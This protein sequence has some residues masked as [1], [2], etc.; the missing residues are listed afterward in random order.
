MN[1]K[2]RTLVILT[3]TGFMLSGCKAELDDFN[4][5]IK[6]ESPQT[7]IQSNPVPQTMDEQPV[8]ETKNEKVKLRTPE[9]LNLNKYFVFTWDRVEYA[10]GY[11]VNVDSVEYS[12]SVN[13]LNLKNVLREKKAYYLYVK[14]ISNSTSFEDSDFSACYIYDNKNVEDEEIKKEGNFS[15]F[16]DVYTQEAFI[17]YGYDVINSSYINSYEVKLNYPIFDFEKVMNKRLLMVKE[18]Q[19]EDIYIS[20]NSMESY[21]QTF[22]AKASAKAKIK[23]AFSGQIKGSFQQTKSSTTSAL[24][25]SYQHSTTCYQLVLQCSFDEYREML[26]PSFKEDLLHLDIGTLFDRYGTHVITSVLMGGRFDL[27]YTMLSDEEIDTS[28][29]SASLD[30][31]FKAWAIDASINVSGDIEEKAKAS[32][33]DIYSTSHVFG[34]NYTQMNNENAILKNYSKWIESIEDKPSLVGIRDVNSLVGIWELLGDSDQ[35]QARKAELERVFEKYGEDSYLELLSNYSITPPTIPQSVDVEVKDNRGNTV[36]L[37]DVANNSTIYLDLHV[38]PEIA[39]IS[40]KVTCDKPDYIE[41]NSSDYSIHIKPETPNGT[42]LYLTID[43]GHGCKDFITLTV[44]RKYTIVFEGNGAINTPA[45]YTNVAHG[46][47]IDEP[48]KPGKEGFVFDGWY[49]FEIPGDQTSYKKFDFE[50][51]QIFDDYV[52]YAKWNKFYPTISYINNFDGLDDATPSFNIEY[53]SILF[54]PASPQ[55]SG[56]T[57]IDFYSDPQLTIPFTFGDSIKNNTIIYC[58]WVKDPKVSFFTNIYDEN[59]DNLE[60]ISVR[61]GEKIDK[62]NP[63]ATGYSLIGFYVDSNF[64]TEFNFNQEIRK[65]TTIYVKFEK[66]TYTVTFD[67][68]GGTPISNQIVKYKEKILNVSTTKEGY[69]FSCW[70][71]DADKK[72]VF[73][74]NIQVIT[75]DLTLYAGW[76]NNPIN[77][78]FD[79]DGGTIF[80]PI[81]RESA[82]PIGD[83][84]AYIPTK[85]GYQ[86]LGWYDESGNRVYS[87]S[88]YLNDVIFTARWKY[89]FY[90]IE[91]NINDGSGE[92]LIYDNVEQGKDF[93]L[94]NITKS[95][96]GYTFAGWSTNQ[97]SRVVVHNDG[98][99]VKDIANPSETIKLYGVWLENTYTISYMVDSSVF[100]TQSGVYGTNDTI[101]TLIPEKDGY[102]FLGWTDKLDNVE[103]YHA[104]DVVEKI[105]T[106]DDVTLYAVFV[107]VIRKLSIKKSRTYGSVDISID[108]T[109]IKSYGT[110]DTG[111]FEYNYDPRSSHNVTV[112]INLKG[113]VLGSKVHSSAGSQLG[114]VDNAYNATVYSVVAKLN[115]TEI[116][117]RNNL[118]DSSIVVD[119]SFMTDGNDMNLDIVFDSENQIVFV[120]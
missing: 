3:T 84:S 73:D 8:N 4:A 32:N 59:V 71:V 2:I 97:F 56:Y 110:S 39:T 43:V 103:K 66:K 72:V 36:N 53:N 98:E 85:V 107:P 108:G 28:K 35:E 42:V 89:I 16:D 94:P 111:S 77:I 81:I 75:C 69:S 109:N 96:E 79:S 52:L 9:N 14:A 106:G 67:T 57:F 118:S 26:S 87:T 11:V 7:E 88:S 23:K 76:T 86:F 29:L 102:E 91:L 114:P 83:L 37:N 38:E 58:K 95:K 51:K 60:T 22:E 41:Y 33:L 78:S 30:T 64:E 68:C 46:S 116:L 27:N 49:Y 62:P 101:T 50:S 20:G 119:F 31:S 54:R 17:G 70:Y 6:I 25:Y 82:T 80:A 1:K 48:M 99:V 100:A 92:Q 113:Y 21:Q 74:P 12:V 40:T 61:Y 44:K 18:R 120:V 93:A 65:D 45:A 34:G 47:T 90:T 112:R 104:G 13:S 15:D 117:Q 10:T 5:N 24:F 105:S 115:G 19:S 63:V 55:F